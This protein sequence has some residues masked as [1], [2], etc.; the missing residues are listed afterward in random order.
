M[1]FDQKI[2]KIW[3][4]P[5]FKKKITKIYYHHC[6]MIKVYEKKKLLKILSLDTYFSYFCFLSFR[7]LKNSY[8]THLLSKTNL[9][10]C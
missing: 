5:K 2:S 6:A 9:N 3:F 1:K 8:S 10:F 7:C 4:Q